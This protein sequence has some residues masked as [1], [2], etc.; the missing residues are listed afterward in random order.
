M[1]VP[2]KEPVLFRIESLAKFVT[3]YNLTF[4]SHRFVSSH[5]SPRT[6]FIFEMITF[7]L[8]IENVVVN[9]RHFLIV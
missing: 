4:V 7:D 1:Y 2:A 6:I 9:N 5:C 3:F 8:Y